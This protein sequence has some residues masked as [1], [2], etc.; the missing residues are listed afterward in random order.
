M[1]A[2]ANNSGVLRIYV[3]TS[4]PWCRSRNC[5]ASI[6]RRCMWQ[7][8]G[9]WPGFGWRAG[10]VTLLLL[11]LRRKSPLVVRRQFVNTYSKVYNSLSCMQQYRSRTKFRP[12]P[13]KQD[14]RRR[15]RTSAEVTLIEKTANIRTKS[16]LL[17]GELCSQMMLFKDISAQTREYIIKLESYHNT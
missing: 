9:G 2:A 6:T 11:L 12:R 3:I 17:Y 1:H 4:C 10:R 13:E 7:K 8:K 15:M 14:D 16:E 5:T